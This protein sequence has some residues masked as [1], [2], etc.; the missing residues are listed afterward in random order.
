MTEA[1]KPTPT[2]R[3]KELETE[4]KKLEDMIMK[5]NHTFGIEKAEYGNGQYSLGFA[6]G[7]DQAKIELA[8]ARADAGISRFFRK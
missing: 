5:L 1:K 2:Q 7:Y 4:I 6:E 8:V 3:V